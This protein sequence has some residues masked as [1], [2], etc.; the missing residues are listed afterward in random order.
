M[1]LLRVCRN[2]INNIEI[3]PIN[4]AQDCFSLCI[5]ETVIE[6]QQ[7]MFDFP[8]YLSNLTHWHEK[9]VKNVLRGVSYACVIC[10]YMG[11]LDAI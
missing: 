8:C 9:G 4:T 11:L 10:G 3:S 5:S 7:V 1:S 6:Y 2:R